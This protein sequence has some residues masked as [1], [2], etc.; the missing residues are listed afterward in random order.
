MAWLEPITELVESPAHLLAGLFDLSP[1]LGGLGLLVVGQ[2]AGA[3]IVH[4][5][6]G[7]DV[8]GAFR[9]HFTCSLTNSTFS[10]TVS[11]VCCGAI[12]VLRICW[13]PI[14]VTSAPMARA[15]APTISAAIHGSRPASM[16]RS[17]IA[18][19]TTSSPA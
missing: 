12:S 7:P 16:S 4:V 9:R 6:A 5:L 18:T 8:A 3:G 19:R 13:T 1:D 2:R 14:E 11:A 17:T 10:R 15:A